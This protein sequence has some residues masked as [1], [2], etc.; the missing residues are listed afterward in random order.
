MYFLLMYLMYSSLCSDRHLIQNLLCLFFFAQWLVGWF[1]LCFLLPDPY[2]KQAIILF[3]NKRDLFEEKIKKVDPV[4]WFP[5]YKG[6]CDYEK[7]AEYFKTRFLEKSEVI[8][9]E[10]FP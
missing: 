5:D 9:K 4:D 10:V 6:G 3:L 2:T 7:G 8:D 1:L